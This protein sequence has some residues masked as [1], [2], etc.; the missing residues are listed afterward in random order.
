MKRGGQPPLLGPAQIRLLENSLRFQSGMVKSFISTGSLKIRDSSEHIAATFL[1]VATRDPFRLKM[2]VTHT[3][4]RPL[5]SILVRGQRVTVIDLYH[6]RTYKGQLGN[7]ASPFGRIPV[8][9][10]TL[11]WSIMRGYPEIMD[12]TTISL[13]DEGDAL[14]VK[15]NGQSSQEIR[16]DG[17]MQYPCTVIYPQLDIKVRFSQYIISDQITYARQVNVNH[18]ANNSSLQININQILFNQSLDP[19]LFTVKIRSIMLANGTSR[20][21]KQHIAAATLASP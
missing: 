9:D 17:K 16:F 1:C 19:S 7:G 11:L 10:R 13:S 21:E 12:D 2:E 6:N 3:W 5:L 4:G 14:V 15:K 20:A 8:F 18:L